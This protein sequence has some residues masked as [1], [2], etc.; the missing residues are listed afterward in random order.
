MMF[1]HEPTDHSMAGP[2]AASE[3]L[4]CW[5]KLEGKSNST[6]YDL[7]REHRGE[8]NELNTGRLHQFVLFG[9]H[10]VHFLFWDRPH[11]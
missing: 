7:I 10:L 11:T 8:P 5:A 6:R 4:E 1:P 3:E 9:F 2:R